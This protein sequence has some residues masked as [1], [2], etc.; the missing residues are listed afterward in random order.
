PARPGSERVMR[1]A[2]RHF[3]LGS[4][5]FLFREIFVRNEYYFEATSDR[6]VVFDCGANIGLATLFFK[7]LY[8][9]CEIHAFEPDPDTFRALQ[10]NVARNGLTDVHLYNVALTDA[11]GR[12]DLFVS[13]GS[14]GSQRASTLSGRNLDRSVRRVV[15]DG[16]P[17]SSH[18]GS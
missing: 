6:P 15:V 18:I 13:G 5:Q 12:L 4:L 3:G 11:P 16:V 1:Y 17:L 8:P 10:E 14:A 9:T 7:W 2:V